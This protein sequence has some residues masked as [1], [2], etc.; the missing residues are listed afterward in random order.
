MTPNNYKVTLSDGTESKEYV[1]NVFDAAQA[2]LIKW[3]GKNPDGEPLTIVDIVGYDPLLENLKILQ[4]INKAIFKQGVQKPYKGIL[5]K[6][7]R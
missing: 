4:R 1:F 7:D 6:E 5:K 3:T 2:A